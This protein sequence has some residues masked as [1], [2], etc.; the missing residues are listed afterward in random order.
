MQM[1]LRKHLA[2]GMGYIPIFFSRDKKTFVSDSTSES[3]LW[4]LLQ[5]FRSKCR[6]TYSLFQNLRSF[7]VQKAWVY[8]SDLRAQTA[9]VMC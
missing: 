6:E 9:G 3:T 7:C 4:T 8:D 2:Q 1:E 5:H